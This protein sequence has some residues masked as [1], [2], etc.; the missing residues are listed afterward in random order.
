MEIAVLTSSRADYGFYKPLLNYGG[1]GTIH[2]NL[3]VFGTHLSRKHGYTVKNIEEDG[4]KIYEKI[5][6][7]INGDSPEIISKSIGKVHIEFAKFWANNKFDYILCLGDRYEMYAA[8][9]ASIPFNIP[10]IHLSGGEETLG[11]ID[12]YYRHALTLMSKIHFTN[13]KKN[14]IRVAQLI[15]NTKNIFHSGSLA[16]DNILSTPLYSV[17]D[18]KKLFSFN[19]ESKFILFTFHPETINFELNI[20]YANEIAKFLSNTSFVILAT[21]PNADTNGNII[22]E[23]LVEIKK[24]N[25]NLFLFESLG[26][27]GYYTAL[28]HCYCVIGNSSSGIVEAASF[29]KYNLNLGDRQKGREKGDNVIDCKINAQEINKML[30]TIS[31]LKKLKTSNIYGDG[32]ASTKIMDKLKKI[33]KH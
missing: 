19:L 17:S 33:E 15:G 8:V 4:I 10:V 5:P 30:N 27:K 20:K 23:K 28:K 21:M 26:S 32:K 24:Q 1:K 11:A 3:I 9:S 18:F 6:T 13:T 7:V 31:N 22:R 12:N 14:A 16:I 2:F 25:S 29:A